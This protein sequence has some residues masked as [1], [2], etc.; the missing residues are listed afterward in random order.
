[1]KK[2]ITLGVVLS[3]ITGG[4]YALEKGKKTLI[5]SLL[6]GISKTASHGHLGIFNLNMQQNKK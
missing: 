2:Y 1:M 5:F 6:L 3:L 4:S